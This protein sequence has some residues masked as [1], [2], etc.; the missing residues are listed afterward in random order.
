MAPHIHPVRARRNGIIKEKI[1]Q[2]TKNL[3]IVIILI[4]NI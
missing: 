1:Q 4:N 3:A 2:L